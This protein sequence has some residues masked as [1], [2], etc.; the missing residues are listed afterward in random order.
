MHFHKRIR[1]TA[2]G[3]IVSRAKFLYDTVDVAE[4]SYLHGVD[5]TTI[6]NTLQVRIS[7]LNGDLQIAENV[8]LESENLEGAVQM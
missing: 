7:A 4:S 6:L 5:E 2:G 8:F 1:L 3:L